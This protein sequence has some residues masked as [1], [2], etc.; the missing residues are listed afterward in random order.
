MISVKSNLFT[1]VMNIHQRLR[2]FS[3]QARVRFL[4]ALG[5]KADKNVQALAGIRWPLCGL[6]YIIIKEN[7]SLGFSGWF[8][9]TREGATISIGY[10]TSIG[11]F[12]HFSADG[13]IHIGNECLFSY[14]VS[15]LSHRHICGNGSNPV[16]SG[17]AESKPILIGNRCFIGCNSVILSGVTLGNNC[18][19]GAN[20]VVTKSF[21]DNSIIGG[22]PARLIK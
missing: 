6:K 5:L 17:Y 11:D 21:P 9:Q 1:L 4:V 10:G 18:V 20:S 14:R 15:V 13:P 16:T 8:S 19:V 12:F 22:S 7:V 3:G 2:N